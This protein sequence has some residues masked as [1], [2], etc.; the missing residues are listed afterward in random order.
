MN[1]LFLTLGNMEDINQRGIYT[2]LVRELGDR[3]LNVYIASP[4]EKRKNLPTELI[5]YENINILKVRIGNIT[6]TK[7]LIEKGISTIRIEGQYLKAIK[8]YFNNIKFNMVIYSTPPITFNKIIKYF[9][10]R[11]NVKS[12]LILKDIF[13]QNAVDMEIMKKGSLIWKYFRRKEINLYKNSDVIGCMSKG[14]LDYILNHNKFIE[15]DKIEIFPNSINPIKRMENREKDVKVLEKYNIPKEKTLFIYGGNLG[16]PQ[17]IDF[18]TEIGDNF[19]K[20]SDSYLLIVGSGTEYRKIENYIE[21][22]QN[23]NISLFKELAKEEYDELINSVDIGLI[24][25]NRRFTIPNFP[26]RL[27][28]YM[29]NSLPILAATDINTDLREVLEESKSGFW[30]RTGDLDSFID[31]AKRLSENMKLRNQMGLNGRMYLEENYD[32]RNTVDILLNHLYGDDSYVS[33]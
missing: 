1:I 6:K 28:S 9:K 13:P 21:K 27:T 4:R 11:D 14:N 29:E 30:C 26:S 17:A 3:G 22:N 18:L 25:L 5:K 19:H 31:Y 10:K 20:V 7:S 15:K 33:R 23:K 12:Y 32:I 24:F 16:K 2:D 8:K